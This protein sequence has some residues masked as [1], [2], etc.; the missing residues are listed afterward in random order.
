[1]MKGTNHGRRNVS[2]IGG[3]GIFSFAIAI[4]QPVPKPSVAKGN[5]GLFSKS[6]GGAAPHLYLRPAIADFSFCSRS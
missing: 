6:I 4:L 5:C 1:M 2:I 3:V